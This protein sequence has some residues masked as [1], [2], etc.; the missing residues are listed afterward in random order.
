MLLLLLL[1]RSRQT[2][3]VKPQCQPQAAALLFSAQN[4][5]GFGFTSLS[6][7]SP[8]P[9]SLTR[10]VTTHQLTHQPDSQVSLVP[11][12][13]VEHLLRHPPPRLRDRRLKPPL[14]VLEPNLVLSPPSPPKSPKS[15]RKRRGRTR[16]TNNMRAREGA[17]AEGEPS[18]KSE[19]RLC[20]DRTAECL[21]GGVATAAP[22]FSS[23][24][25]ATTSSRLGGYTAVVEGG[26]GLFHQASWP[27]F[28]VDMYVDCR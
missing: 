12:P 26:G 20:V 28:Y 2:T 27:E 22:E 8:G 18:G 24:G 10:S 14:L 25:P 23:S 11:V 3:D 21:L 7:D 6:P 4:K 13:S 1:P 9:L 5:A 19:A 17:C 16:G 15:P